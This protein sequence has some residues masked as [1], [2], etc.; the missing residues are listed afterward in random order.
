MKGLL[1]NRPSLE[2]TIGAFILTILLF[3]VFNFLPSWLGFAMTFVFLN[4]SNHV[5]VTVKARR[6]HMKV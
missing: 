1:D 2:K 5:A 3:F 4:V 6:N